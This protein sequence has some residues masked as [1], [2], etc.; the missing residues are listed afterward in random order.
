[1]PKLHAQK[2]DNKSHNSLLASLE[3]KGHVQIGGFPGRMDGRATDQSKKYR[4]CQSLLSRSNTT[5]TT[6][7]LL[8]P[9]SSLML[10]AKC[11]HDKLGWDSFIKGRMCKLWFVAREGNITR[12]NLRTTSEFWARGLIRR[13]LQ[14][15]HRQCAKCMDRLPRKGGNPSSRGLVIVRRSTLAQTKALDQASMNQTCVISK[16]WV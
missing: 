3:G 6:I 5:M 2:W 12:S 16:F 15:T 4:P 8:E 13:L 11:P 10:L 9:K 7:S 1:M 14:L